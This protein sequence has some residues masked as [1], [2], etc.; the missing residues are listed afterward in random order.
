[1]GLFGV[2]PTGGQV[3]DDG[4]GRMGVLGNGKAF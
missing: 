2:G 4:V 3:T 1:M